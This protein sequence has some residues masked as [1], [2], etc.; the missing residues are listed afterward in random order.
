MTP[1]IAGVCANAEPGVVALSD[2]PDAGVPCCAV[3]VS[4][5]RRLSIDDEEIV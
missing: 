3:D 5:A 4:G 1:T 2:P